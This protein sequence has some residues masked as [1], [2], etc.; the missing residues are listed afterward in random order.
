MQSENCLEMLKDQ[1][2]FKLSFSHNCTRVGKG[3]LII[4]IESM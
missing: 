1:I 4:K 2:I 3:A